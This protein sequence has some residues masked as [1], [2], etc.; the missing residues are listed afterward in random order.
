MEIASYIRQYE[1]YS[2]DHHAEILALCLENIDRHDVLLDC[3]NMARHTQS[4]LVSNYD[5]DRQ[6]SGS[7]DDMDACENADHQ[8]CCWLLL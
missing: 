1:A 6:R 4:D 5:F 8:Y 3:L 7:D 2:L